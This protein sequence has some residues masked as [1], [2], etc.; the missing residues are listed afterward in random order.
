MRITHSIVVA[1]DNNIV[2]YCGYEGK[3]TDE[4]LL[5]LEKEL[6]SD[7]NLEGPFI[8]ADGPQELTDWIDGMKDKKD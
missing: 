2:H 5:S 7:F 1:K 6:V 3:P 4:D 8:F